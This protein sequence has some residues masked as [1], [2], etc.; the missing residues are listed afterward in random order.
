MSMAPQPHN[1]PYVRSAHVAPRFSGGDIANGSPTDVESRRD[2]T[3]SHLLRQR[4]NFG[5][6]TR[7]QLGASPTIGVLG[8]SNGFQMCWVNTKAITA[9]VVKVQTA[10][11]VA[12]VLPVE[13]AV[14]RFTYPVDGDLSVSV[15]GCRRTLPHPT[16]GGG[17]DGVRRGMPTPSCVTINKAL[18]FTPDVAVLRQ[19]GFLRQTRSLATSALAK[20]RRI[21]SFVGILRTHFSDLLYRSG[22]AVPGACPALPGVSILAKTAPSCGNLAMGLR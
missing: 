4:T 15:A 20:A 22:G 14:C 5:Y 17:V 7:C 12:L 13:P 19:I 21:R 6:L 8:R 16:S 18:G 2:V 10:G 1:K 9:Q 11:N 3:N